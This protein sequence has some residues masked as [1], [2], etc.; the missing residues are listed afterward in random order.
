M[1]YKSAS[2]HENALNVLQMS[3]PAR[4]TSLRFIRTDSDGRK[5]TA[6][7]KYLSSLN[8]HDSAGERK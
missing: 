8:V 6:T 7:Q 5:V 1:Y 2:P 4:E 3:L